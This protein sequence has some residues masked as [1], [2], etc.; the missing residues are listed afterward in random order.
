MV[1]SRHGKSAALV[2]AMLWNLFSLGVCALCWVFV[3]LIIAH[4]VTTG[5]VGYLVLF[6]AA[7][8]AST[9]LFGW[10]VVSSVR[11]ALGGFVHDHRSEKVGNH[12]RRK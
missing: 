9:Y 7:G 5:E 8:L 1:Q 6:A 2:K 10:L 4:G 11:L 12:E 3:A